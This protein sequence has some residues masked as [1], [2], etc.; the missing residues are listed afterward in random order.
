MTPI[1]ILIFWMGLRPV[2]FTGASEA[3][4][5]QMLEAAKAPPPRTLIL[6]DADQTDRASQADQTELTEQE[7]Q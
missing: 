7:A 5:S 6:N 4:V 2:T 1:V 3:T